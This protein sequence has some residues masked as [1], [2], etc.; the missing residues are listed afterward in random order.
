MTFQNVCLTAKG[1]S[2]INAR[3]FDGITLQGIS[4]KQNESY[5]NDY[6]I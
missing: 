5:V 1:D 3:I 2:M 6:I 4:D